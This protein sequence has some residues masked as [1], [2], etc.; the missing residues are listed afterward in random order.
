MSDDKLQRIEDKIDKIN[1]RLSNIDV[2]LVKQEANLEKH[3]LRTE[4][5]EK[6]INHLIDDSKPIKSH[7]TLMN[8]LAK[9]VIFLGVVA[10]IYKNL[11]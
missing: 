10:A 8:N 9:I 11:H 2:T 7:V 4:Q 5:N 3:M 6:L 1:D